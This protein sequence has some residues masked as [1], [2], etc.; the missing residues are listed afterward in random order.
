M[1]F[2]K[3]TLVMATLLLC[4]IPAIAVAEESPAAAADPRTAPCKGL[5][6]FNNLDEL[7][8]QFYINLDSDCLF[9][10]STKELEEVWNIK[11][12]DDERAKP[13]NFYPLSETEFY[14]K[15]YKSEKDTFYLER[16]YD[17][18]VGANIFII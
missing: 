1:D 4:S 12:L 8:Y 2:R 13:K 7:L 14:N 5:K 15:P 3:I 6:P 9:E 16:T 18:H 17:P 11:I 10:I